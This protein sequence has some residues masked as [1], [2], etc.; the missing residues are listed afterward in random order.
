MPLLMVW[1]GP[2]IPLHPGAHF[3]YTA[4][5]IE[6]PF[7]LQ[8]PVALPKISARMGPMSAPRAIYIPCSRCV[9]EIQS[10]GR[11]GAATPTMTA[12]WPTPRWTKPGRVP[13]ATASARTPQ[14]RG[15]SPSSCTSAR[16]PLS[17]GPWSPLLILGVGGKDAAPKL[18]A[19][20]VRCRPPEALLARDGS[21][22]DPLGHDEALALRRGR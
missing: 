20:P 15:W 9:P 4:R 13:P 8:Y 2:R 5:C 19:G 1:L 6:P 18:A 21:R 7:P 11:S 3:S 22:A 14:S 12:S 17:V 16:G 10:V